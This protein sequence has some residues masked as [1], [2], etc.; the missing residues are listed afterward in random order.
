MSYPLLTISK[1][2]EHS[3][4]RKHPWVFSGA[5][6]SD[7]A[8]LQDGDLVCLTTKKQQILGIGHYQ[9]AT[10]AVRMLSFDYETIDQAFYER[11]LANAYQLVVRE[12]IFRT[13]KRI[14]QNFSKLLQECL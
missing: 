14:R 5:I 2:K 1:G 9:P 10:I 12:R 13:M 8:E 7:T 11:R 4:Q 6:A 3:I